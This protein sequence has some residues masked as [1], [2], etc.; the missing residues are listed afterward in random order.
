M[1]VYSILQSPRPCEDTGSDHSAMTSSIAS[2]I[3][4][5]STGRVIDVVTKRSLT[6]RLMEAEE[7][8]SC[9]NGKFGSYGGRFVP[10][11]LIASLNGLEDEFYSALRDTAFQVC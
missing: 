8:K 10:E 4:Q 2:R 11:T 1:R 9:G 5:S 3:D 7:R 6:K